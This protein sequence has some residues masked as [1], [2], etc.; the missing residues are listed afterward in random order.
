VRHFALGYGSA[1]PSAV[2]LHFLW[3][4]C[5][6]SFGSVSTFPWVR[7]LHGIGFGRCICLGSVGTLQS[8]QTDH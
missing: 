3:L 1:F 5:F 4:G 7:M 2:L 6:I 8:G